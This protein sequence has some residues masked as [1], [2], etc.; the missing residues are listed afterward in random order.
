MRLGAPHAEV[1]KWRASLLPYRGRMG[2]A[3]PDFYWTLYAVTRVVYTLNDYGRRRPSPRLPPEEF[4]F[5][6][7]NLDEAMALRDAEMMGEFP[8]TLIESSDARADSASVTP[9]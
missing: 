5:Q 4:E 2:G 8:D 3:N 1:L 6:R 7:Q 9:G